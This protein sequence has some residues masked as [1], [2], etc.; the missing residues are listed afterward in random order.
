MVDEA[1]Q[2]QLLGGGKLKHLLAEKKQGGKEGESMKVS[3][4]MEIN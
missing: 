3:K 1:S 2:R 4:A